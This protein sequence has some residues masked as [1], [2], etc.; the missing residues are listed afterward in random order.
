VIFGSGGSTSSTV[1]TVNNAGNAQFGGTLLVGGT[2]QST[3]TMTV[4]NNADA[5][6]DYYLWPGA[7]TSQK[8]SYTYKDW[9]GNSQ[10]YMV[11]D[12]SNN[13]AL[14]SAIGGLDSFKAYQ[15]TNSGDTYVNA[16]NGSGAVRVNYETGAGATFNIYGG[17]SS[18]LYASFTGAASIKFPGLAAGSGHNCVQIDNSGYISNTGVAC[19][20]GGGTVGTANSGQIAYYTGTGTAIGGMNQVPMSAGGTGSST[21]VGALSNLGAQ[22]AIAGLAS[23]GV[24]GVAVLGGGSFGGAVRAANASFSGTIAAGSTTPTLMGNNGITFP[25]S[26]VQATASAAPSYADNG[27]L[28]LSNSFA[29]SGDLCQRLNAMLIHAQTSAGSGGMGLTTVKVDASGMTGAQGCSVNPFNGV[30]LAGG[31]IIWPASAVAMQTQLS[32]PTK[33]TVLGAGELSGTTANSLMVAAPGF[34]FLQQPSTST[35][36]GTSSTI[37]VP[38]SAYIMAGDVVVTEGSGDAGGWDSAWKV[39]AVPDSTHITIPYTGSYTVTSGQTQTISNATGTCGTFLTGSFQSTGTP[40]PDWAISHGYASG[41]VL[42]PLLNNANSYVYQGTAGT[43]SGTEP[44]TWNSTAVGGTITDGGVTWTNL[45]QVCSAVLT[46]PS[47]HGMLGPGLPIT[48]SGITG[49]ASILNGTQQVVASTSITSGIYQL[50]V[51]YLGSAFNVT[52]PGNVTIVPSV[53]L[54]LVNLGVGLAPVTGTAGADLGAAL[55]DVGVDTGGAAGITG[56]VA[57]FSTTAN[58]RTGVYGVFLKYFCRAGLWV[59]RT[60]NGSPADWSANDSQASGGQCGDPTSSPLPSNSHSGAGVVVYNGGTGIEG[61]KSW[62]IRPNQYPNPNFDGMR[63]GSISGGDIEDVHIELSGN[64][65]RFTN[66]GTSS[67]ASGGMHISGVTAGTGAFYVS[68]LFGSLIRLDKNSASQIEFSGLSKGGGAW[69]MDDA[70]GG[71]QFQT[72]G[73]GALSDLF[74]SEYTLLT[75]TAIPLCSASNISLEGRWPTPQTSL[76]WNLRNGSG[77]YIGSFTYD[78]SNNSVLSAGTSNPNLLLEPNGG[79]TGTSKNYGMWLSN[80]ASPCIYNST[81]TTCTGISAPTGATPADNAT[82][83]AGAQWWDSSYFYVCTVS[84]TVKRVTLSSF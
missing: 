57:V 26:T 46:L 19:G 28:N 50:Y 76:R 82:C 10:W 23:D 7:T 83:T 69:I 65:L 78:S 43:S 63:L 51:N 24:N 58:E 15:S 44:T 12:A 18:S 17:N 54:P 53:T 72:A 41:T 3:G 39:T 4:R 6:V 16:S 9:N 49:T 34:T 38:S 74:C 35:V 70:V 48:V 77:T 13:W 75:S 5:E 27:Y 73:T 66:G 37:Q 29:G 81:G 62:T 40:Y 61:L 56:S 47:S 2:S 20:T 1:A 84:G 80:S 14:N 52:S 22:A 21:A 33:W 30:T 60:T 8:G 31:E 68:G 59:V 42:M 71:N 36:S 64:G 67:Q 32:I 11:K 45:G 79:T 25:D 55:R